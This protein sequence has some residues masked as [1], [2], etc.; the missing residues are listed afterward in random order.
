MA[1]EVKVS[2]PNSWLMQFF[3]NVTAWFGS[4]LQ[5]LRGSQ[6]NSPTATD[7]VGVK[8]MQVTTVFACVRLITECVGALDAVVFR[9]VGDDRY[10]MRT[11]DHWIVPLLTVAPNPLQTPL[12]FFEQLILNLLLDGNAYALKARV[13]DRVVALYPLAASQ[14]DVIADERGIRYV[15]RNPE[16]R[17]IVYAAADVVH[18]KLFGNGLKG[19]SPL[20]YAS[21]AIEN[22]WALQENATK[23]AQAGNKPGGTLMVDRVLKPD[24]R[25]AVRQNFKDLE[26][27][28]TKLF[29]LEAG[30][31]YE[32]ISITPEEAQM[33]EQ[34]KFSVDDIARVFRVPSH[35]V[36]QSGQASTWGSGL[37][38]M[39]LA[40]L[41]YTL[42][43]YLERVEQALERAL[44]SDAE[45]DVVE[46]EFDL[47][48]LMRADS[49][50]R[51]EYISS[52]VQN[53]VMTRNEARRAEGRAGVTDENADALTVQVN[54]TPLAKLGEN[55]QSSGGTA[56]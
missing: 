30:M 45:R 17:Q 52:M 21:R 46:I 51:S 29:V 7:P 2:Q 15:Y 49:K 32:K 53:G 38:Q 55:S 48:P 5:Q 33:M 42:T 28:N 25:E 1:G 31:K 40:F 43:P 54:L 8:S 11:R 3:A 14:V 36:N 19:L 6:A 13:G 18:V 56:Q 20:G 10:R 24:Q 35:M 27:A 50:A 34:R 37:E 16:G 39:N 12:E 23:L 26:E 9:R 47:T 22:A 44:L 4:G 41:T